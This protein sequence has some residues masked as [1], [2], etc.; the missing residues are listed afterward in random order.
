M[1]LG[2]EKRS[3]E[4]SRI[5]DTIIDSSENDIWGMGE[6]EIKRQQWSG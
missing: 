3:S 4:R 5:T 1:T 2:G 6:G